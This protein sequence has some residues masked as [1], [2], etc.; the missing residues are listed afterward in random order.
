MCTEEQTGLR[1]TSDIC[2]SQSEQQLFIYLLICVRFWLEEA[3]LTF[4]YSNT[5]IIY[6]FRY[7]IVDISV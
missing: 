2:W 6:Y 1:N 4:T 5:S 7:I 3:E